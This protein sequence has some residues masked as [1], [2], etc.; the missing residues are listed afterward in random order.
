LAAA[1]AKLLA[2]EQIASRLDDRFRM[3]VGG[4]RIA[5]PRQ[6]TLRAMIDWSYD[7]LSEEEQGLLRTASVFVGG[8]TLDALEAVADAPNTIEYLD[9]LINKS[10]VVTEERGNEMRYFMLETIRQ[11]AREKL[12]DA[13]QASAAR[14][15]HLIYFDDLSERMWNGLRLP[16]LFDWRDRVDDE[17]ENLRAA[18][19]WAL[20]NHI[21]D[22][23]HLAA[24]FCVITG[25]MGDQTEGLALVKTA[26]ER[27]KSLPPVDGH[28]HTHR[29]KLIAKA[30]YAE[31]LVALGQGNLPLVIQVLQEAIT[32]SR[33][34][35]DKLILGFSLEMY[36]TASTLFNA[37]GGAEAAQEG[38]SIFTDEVDDKFGLAMA[39]ANMARVAASKGDLGEKKKY[40]EKI[41]GLIGEI[42]LSFQTGLIL[43]GMGMDES[44]QGNYETATTLFEDG[45]NI[46]K[47]LRSK[48]FQLAMTSELGHIARHTGDLNQAKKIYGETII[49]WQDLGHRP[50][51]AHQLECFAF[52]AIA[53]EEPQRAI[54][55]LGAAEALREKIGSP[56]ASYEV[57]E[58]HKEVAQLR[59]MLAEAEFNAFWAEGRAM[60]MEQAIQFALEQNA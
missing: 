44:R 11:Y 30:L 17:L 26:V 53:E 14:D 9:Q 19:E 1:R 25:W 49:G 56:M 23:V 2:P 59:T 15:R 47:R 5:L 52:V 32:I 43:M 16:D 12:F 57:M 36:F 35:G 4:S 37:P 29:Q 39:Y 3:L 34:T 31:S 42:P 51:I 48:N 18:L 58:Y 54:K 20:E 7:L 22:A 45:L 27:T 40:S 8:W 33:V 10:L 6:Q 41:R 21:E 28:A 55:L 24:N 50:A 13:K 60:T 46:F 38:L